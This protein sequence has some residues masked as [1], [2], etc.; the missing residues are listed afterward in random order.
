M[1]GHSN[2]PIVVGVDGSSTA[3]QALR[4]AAS[5]DCRRGRD[6]IA[7]LAWS[8]LDQHR[9]DPEAGFDPGY[10]G[11]DALKALDEI[12]ARAVDTKT[13]ASIQRHVVCDL[14]VRALVDGSVGASLLVMGARGAGGFPSL[15]L[16]S[17]SSRVLEK[18]GAPVA[19]VRS[20][21]TAVSQIIVGVDGS[22]TGSVALEWAV[23]EAQ[24]RNCRIV[25][26]HAWT[27]PA[28]VRRVFLDDAPI[29]KELAGFAADALDAALWAVDVKDVDV[30]RRLVQG[31]A[32]G[33]LL[34]GASEDSLLV[35]GSRG[36][37]AAA[38]A[39]LGSVTRQV[40]QHATCPLVVVPR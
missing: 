1:R 22:D 20:D 27:A 39:V 15:L 23:Q 40:A 2:R 16:G 25:A 24:A 4:W 9:L 18:V 21:A 3:D 17:T 34:D 10:S 12:V 8:L 37:S 30:E 7:L 5:D 31:N 38:G 32:A 33:A 28:L 6:V 11:K 36:L 29:F 13:A 19:L 26:I 14:A 35:V